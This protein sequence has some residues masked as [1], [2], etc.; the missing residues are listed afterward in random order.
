MAVARQLVELATNQLIKTSGVHLIG[1]GNY[2][3]FL[4][5][6]IKL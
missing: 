1:V 3:I 5:G 4:E 6:L 2:R